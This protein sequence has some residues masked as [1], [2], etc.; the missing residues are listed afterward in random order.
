M[1]T[2]NLDKA[3]DAYK[4]RNVDEAIK[5]HSIKATEQHQQGQGKYIKSMVYGG[6]D[7]IITTFA[8]VAGAAG[9]SAV[10]DQPFGGGTA[11]AGEEFGARGRAVRTLG[12]ITFTFS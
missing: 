2:R 6:L 1:L 9:A 4:K 8:V 3:R 12:K 5:A 7:G 11:P 10:V